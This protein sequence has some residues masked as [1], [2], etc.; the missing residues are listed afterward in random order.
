MEPTQE[1]KDR[2]ALF[3][4]RYEEL[5]NELHVDFVNYPLFQPNQQGKWEITVQTQP[6]DTANQPIKSPFVQQ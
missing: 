5:V 4:K 2:L 1:V 6:V 3:M